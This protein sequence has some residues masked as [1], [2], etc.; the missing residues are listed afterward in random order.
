M[1]RRSETREFSAAKLT[2][3]GLG[4]V[5]ATTLVVKTELRFVLDW[6]ELFGNPPSAKV[7][8]QARADG[9]IV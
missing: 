4:V 8:F 6:T 7:I 9:K 5:E 2:R 3:T 1:T